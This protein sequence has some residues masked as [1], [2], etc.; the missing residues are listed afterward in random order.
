MY[1]N[2]NFE[3]LGINKLMTFDPN[4]IN[5]SVLRYIHL[6]SVHHTNTPGDY[7]QQP[8]ISVESL[9]CSNLT[10]VTCCFVNVS[11]PPKGQVWLVIEINRKRRVGKKGLTPDNRW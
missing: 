3:I 1:A 11:N 4:I 10:V 8:I 9:Y 5:Q 2:L 7:N 6:G